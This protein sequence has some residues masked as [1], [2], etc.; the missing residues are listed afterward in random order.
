MKVATLNKFILLFII[1][2]SITGCSTAF[3]MPDWMD[4]DKSREKYAERK[5]DLM[6][7]QQAKFKIRLSSFKVT[8]VTAAQLL[9]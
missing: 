3:D 9:G 8:F 4:S 6:M 1:C 7:G 5:R 2:F